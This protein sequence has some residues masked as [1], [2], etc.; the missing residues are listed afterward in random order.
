[1]SDIVPRES[2]RVWKTKVWRKGSIT[3]GKPSRPLEL[4]VSKLFGTTVWELSD[5][6]RDVVKTKSVSETVFVSSGVY[7]VTENKVK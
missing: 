5:K 4:T 7:K 6:L 1:M 2:H 3:L